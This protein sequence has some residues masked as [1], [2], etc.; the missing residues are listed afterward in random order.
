MGSVKLVL[1]DTPGKKA[2][3]LQHMKPIPASTIWIF[4]RTYEGAP[5]HSMN[6]MEPFDIAFLD[7]EG[8][9]LGGK[10]ITPQKETISAPR[11][12]EIAIESKA[13][14]FSRLGIEPGKKI[15]MEALL[16]QKG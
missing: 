10:T 1:L 14:M 16:G 11:G 15:N 8:T 2:K 6:V 7:K 13:G 5:F 4:T 12:A 3:G 9:V